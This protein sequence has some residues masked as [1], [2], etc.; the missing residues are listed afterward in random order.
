[1]EV[2]VNGKSVTVPAGSTVTMLIRQLS[3]GGGKIAV[4]LNRDIVPR[5]HYDA[6]QLKEGDQLEIVQAI[7]GG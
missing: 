4:E 6:L 7:G 2:S 3:L 5:S 1:M